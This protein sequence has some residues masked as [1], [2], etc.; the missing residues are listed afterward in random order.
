MKINNTIFLS[1][2]RCPYKPGLL[3]GN[4]IAC[5]TDYQILMADHLLPN[6]FCSRSVAMFSTVFRATTRLLE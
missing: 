2:L 1:Y 3:L 6:N 5:P 4:Q